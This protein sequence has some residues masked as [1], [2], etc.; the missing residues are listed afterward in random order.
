MD[1]KTARVLVVEDDPDIQT[2]LSDLFVREGYEVAVV[3]NGA[4]AIMFLDEHDR[5]DVVLVDLLMPG[6]IGNELLEYLSTDAELASIP[7][8]IVS[9]SPQL[10]PD[11]YTVFKKPIDIG[12]LLAF[13]RES[14]TRTAT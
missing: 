5:P 2:T 12:P 6:V 1:S 10:A 4:E 13:V 14:A 9:G 11:G 7:I 8:A 3:P